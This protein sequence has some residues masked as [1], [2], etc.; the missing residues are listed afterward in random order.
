MKQEDLWI[1]EAIPYYL[2]ERQEIRQPY[3][4]VY[5]ILEDL[6][7]RRGLRQEWENISSE[8]QDDIIIKWAGIIRSGNHELNK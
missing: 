2:G 1:T 7:S 3:R 4:V 5:N 8:I 6:T